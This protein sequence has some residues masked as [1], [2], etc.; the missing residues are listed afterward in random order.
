[1]SMKEL[2]GLKNGSPRSWD[3]SDRLPRGEQAGLKQSKSLS[4]NRL[5]LYLGIDQHAKQLT[6]SLRGG[7]GDVILNRQVSTEQERCLEFLTQLQVKAGDDGSCD[8][9][10]L[11]FQRLAA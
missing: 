2:G 4:E 3:T 7:D 8:R 1:M 5:M 9:R 11:R 10:S 6:V